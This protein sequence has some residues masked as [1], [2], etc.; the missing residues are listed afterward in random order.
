MTDFESSVANTAAEQKTK[1]AVLPAIILTILLLALIASLFLCFGRKPDMQTLTEDAKKI[2]QWE[3]FY[4]LNANKDASQGLQ[5]YLLADNHLVEILPKGNHTARNSN[6]AAFSKKYIVWDRKI[7]LKNVTP[8]GIEKRDNSYIAYIEMEFE[9]KVVKRE[10]LSGIVL[11][12]LHPLGYDYFTDSQLKTF[13]TEYF[14]IFPDFNF[15]IR[16]IM[17][18]QG[19]TEI[20]RLSSIVKV[21]WNQK[22]KCW[23]SSELTFRTADDLKIP[24]AQ[25]TSDEYSQ[26]NLF[27]KLAEKNI[28]LYSNLFYSEKDIEILEKLN[29]G[30]VYYEGEW[31]AKEVYT[32]TE[33]LKKAIKKFNSSKFWRDLEHAISLLETNT[34]AMEKV[35]KD[36]TKQLRDVIL[37]EIEHFKNKKDLRNLQDIRSKMQRI[38]GVAQLDINLFEPQIAEAEAAIKKEREAEELRR[39]EQ[40][41][42]EERREQDRINELNQQAKDIREYIFSENFRKN[43]RGNYSEYFIK[44][45]QLMQR[46]SSRDN[47][48]RDFL[49]SAD[50][51]VIVAAFLSDS[52]DH[53][54]RHVSQSDIS[55]VRS[56]IFHNCNACKDGTAICDDCKGTRRCKACNGRG[57]Y[58]VTSVS[59]NREY[60]SCPGR[61]Q[62]CIRPKL[63]RKCRGKRFIIDQNGAR[64]FIRELKTEME[65]F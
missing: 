11:N 58:T 43:F 23:T 28:K 16:K 60:R 9:Q 48:Y 7:E 55:T 42:A 20:N 5:R 64:N 24:R 12:K 35:R 34:T 25:W 31:V 33:N 14:G 50:R 61:C 26:E 30:Q 19:K 59:G 51:Y 2:S 52:V 13:Q 21:V 57:Y 22:Q 27:K 53:I 10:I 17:K 47:K 65:K 56:A 46:L 32:A 44:R 45:N 8:L 18:E 29:A 39:A 15:D 37:A 40:R 49:R 54:S 4:L 41:K 6:G 1:S 36:V 3:L 38:R 62:S 63:C